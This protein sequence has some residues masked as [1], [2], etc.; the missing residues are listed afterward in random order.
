M[1]ENQRRKE[2]HYH[3]ISQ[4]TCRKV[5]NK[6]ERNRFKHQKTIGTCNGLFLPATSF[7]ELVKKTLFWI[8]EKIHTEPC[9]DTGNN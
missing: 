9:C 1:P 3:D 4:Q 2:L 6:S 8:S 5:K 7:L